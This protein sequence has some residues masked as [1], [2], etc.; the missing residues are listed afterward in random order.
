[1]GILEILRASLLKDGFREF[2]QSDWDCYGDAERFKEV[3]NNTSDEP[4]IK[5]DD[6]NEWVLILDNS[7]FHRIGYYQDTQYFE[8]V[9][10]D[11]QILG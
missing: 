7:G 8:S 4:I 9:Y 2:T 10:F 6:E 3:S 11:H 5:E 1:M